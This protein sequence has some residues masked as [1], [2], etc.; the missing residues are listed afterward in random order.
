MADSPPTATSPILNSSDGDEETLS[1]VSLGDVEMGQRYARRDEVYDDYGPSADFLDDDITSSGSRQNRPS[2]TSSLRPLPF[3][4]QRHPATE[5]DDAYSTSSSE[6]ELLKMSFS[7]SN[8]HGEDFAEMTDILKCTL[9]VY[10]GI[11]SMCHIA[12]ILLAVFAV[13]ITESTRSSSTGLWLLFIY[14]IVSSLFLLIVFRLQYKKL[15]K[16]FSC[17]ECCRKLRDK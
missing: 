1:S 5:K 13:M 4:K 6:D 16:M 12:L 15:H 7:S 9:V 10:V 17:T 2:Q 8:K 11:F 3:R 14:A